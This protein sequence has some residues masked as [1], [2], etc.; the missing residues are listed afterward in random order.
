MLPLRAVTARRGTS[1]RGFRL[2]LHNM[3]GE[4][5]TQPTKTREQGTKIVVSSTVL[6]A[7]LGSKGAL[8]SL[9]ETRE[10]DASEFPPEVR[11]WF[12]SLGFAYV[13][14]GA[15]PKEIK[16]GEATRAA[17]PQEIT[18]AVDAR[19][20]E[21][22]AGVMSKRRQSATQAERIAR[23]IALEMVNAALMAANKTAKS[24]QKQEMAE[25]LFEQRKDDLL[26][27]ALNRIEE[28]KRQ[29]DSAGINLSDLGL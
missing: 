14:R 3:E 22:K 27:K 11:A 16:E 15:I 12:M 24:E 28:A 20:A 19:I 25:R 13:L 26:A 29:A 21:L 5:T 18:E 2:G 9:N 23:E 10:V 4:Q 7:S 6:S 8:A 1:G 17:T